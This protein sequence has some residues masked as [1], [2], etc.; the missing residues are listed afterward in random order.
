MT[1]DSIPGRIAWSFMVPLYRV[2]Q[3]LF[4]HS[5]SAPRV[6][7]SARNQDSKGGTNPENTREHLAHLRIAEAKDH[8]PGY[9]EGREVLGELAPT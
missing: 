2:R 5:L 4:F 3:E 7:D 8:G 9:H 1:W 6:P